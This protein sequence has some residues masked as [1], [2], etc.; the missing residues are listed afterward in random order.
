MF[1]VEMDQLLNRVTIVY[2]GAVGP[3]ETLQCAKEFRLALAETKPGFRLLVDMTNLRTMDVLCAPHL[4]SLMDDCNENGIAQV[5]RIIPNPKLD[6]GFQIMSHFHYGND[7]Q[8]VTCESLNEAL[9]VLA[10]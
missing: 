5:V 10:R 4:R 2:S 8:V 7:V 1:K 3:S 9:S 6:I